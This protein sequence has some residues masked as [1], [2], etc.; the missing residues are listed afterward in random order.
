MAKFDPSTG[1]PLTVSIPTKHT[2]QV[3]QQSRDYGY[4]RAQEDPVSPLSYRSNEKF[5]KMGEPGSEISPLSPSSKQ[6]LTVTSS[7]HLPPINT[8]TIPKRKPAGGWSVDHKGNV[9]IGVPSKDDSANV[10]PAPG[11]SVSKEKE[12]T[13]QRPRSKTSAVRPQQDVYVAPDFLQDH[14]DHLRAA[15]QSKRIAA[16]TATP[17]QQRSQSCTG[18]PRRPSIA[19]AQRNCTTCGRSQTSSTDI[20]RQCNK[21]TGIYFCTVECWDKRVCHNR[22]RERLQAAPVITAHPPKPKTYR[23]RSKER[24]QST[25]AIQAQ[26]PK[27]QAYHDRSTK[28]QQAAPLLPAQQSKPRPRPREPPRWEEP[29]TLNHQKSSTAPVSN[30]PSAAP[31]KYT[32]RIAGEYRGNEKSPSESSSSTRRNGSRTLWL[33]VVGVVCLVLFIVIIVLASKHVKN[34]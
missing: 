9:V 23:N 26:Q 2:P 1:K 14:A 3:I 34:A 15:P 25:S 13:A 31:A 16:T 29:P 21:C 30:K 19:R 4:D 24:Q 27:P 32:R 22:S 6:T 10:H 33:S 5:P 12:T 8:Y 20:F 18:R 7:K 28:R 17:K 11:N